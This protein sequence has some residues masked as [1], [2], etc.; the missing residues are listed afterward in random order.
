MN[1]VKFIEPVWS[2]CKNQRWWMI[3]RKQNFPDKWG[4][5]MYELRETVN[6]FTGPAE[7]KA[8]QKGGEVSTKSHP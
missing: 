8:R 5:F 4:R 1:G 6:A 7:E 2:D 3:L